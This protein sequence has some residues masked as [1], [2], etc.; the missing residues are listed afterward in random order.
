MFQYLTW[1]GIYL[2]LADNAC[3]VI[4]HDTQWLLLVCNEIYKT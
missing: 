2:K 4:I 3:C 1:V